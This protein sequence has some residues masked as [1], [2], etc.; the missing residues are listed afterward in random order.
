VADADRLNEVLASAPGRIEAVVHLAARAGVRR[1][2]EEPHLYYRTNVTGT[3]SLVEAA[4]RNEIPKLVLASTSS[5]YAGSTRIP[6]REDDPADRPLSPYTASKRAAEL[7]C[8]AY[9][10]AFGLDVTVLRYFTVYGPAGRP[11]MS[12]FRFI[13]WVTEG[14]PVTVFGDGTQSRDFTYV[15]DVADG[16]VLALRPSGF[17][18]INLGG[19][20]PVELRSVL[21]MVESL[22]GGPATVEH[23]PFHRADVRASWA[24]ISAAERLLGWRPKVSLEEGLAA[25]VEWYRQNRDWA[26][27]LQL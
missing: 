23:H 27:E 6:F 21:G 20:H 11:D 1:S 22:V 8:H 15:T 16:T 7:C 10:K 17:A 19:D 18:V 4:R 14:E 25:T 5:V 2:L 13:R 9:H 26:R 24:D 12:I 3:L